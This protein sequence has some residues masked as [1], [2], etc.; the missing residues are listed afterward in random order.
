MSFQTCTVC[1]YLVEHKKI[2]W[3]LLALVFKTGFCSSKWQQQQKYYKWIIKWSIW[4][5]PCTLSLLKPF[6]FCVKKMN[7]KAIERTS[8]FMTTPFPSVRYFQ[9]NQLIQFTKPVWIILIMIHCKSF[10]PISFEALNQIS[11]ICEQINYFSQ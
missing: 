5:E 10:L 1:F 8:R 3:N 2:W 4:L 11:M 9:M 6:E 7:Q